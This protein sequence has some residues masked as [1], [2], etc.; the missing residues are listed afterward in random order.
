VIVTG[1]DVNA[2]VGVDSDSTVGLVNGVWVGII[3][4]GVF[5]FTSMVGANVG[6]ANGVGA[7]AGKLL[8]ANVNTTPE[9]TKLIT[10]NKNE[11]SDFVRYPLRS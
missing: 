5:V 4:V 10:L 6:E 7:G 8:Y 1:V 3:F 9:A 2:G 11:V